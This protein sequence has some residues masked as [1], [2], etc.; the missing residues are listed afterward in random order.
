V[1]VAALAGLGGFYLSLAEGKFPC[2]LCFYQRSFALAV[3]A[4]LLTG[5]IGGLNSR[6]CLATLALPLAVAGLGVALWH[7]DLERR[8][9]LTCPP[10]LFGVATAPQ[11]S[12]I[13]F[14]LLCALLL[15]DTYQ[16][17]RMGNDFRAVAGAVVL[18]LALAAACC[19]SGSNKQPVR[20]I[21]DAEYEGSRRICLPPQKDR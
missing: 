5:Q 12:M 16:P 1:V 6:I 4:V 21:P 17:G 10:G 3:F 8:G 15:L 13:A 9:A 14:A 2:P 18:G 20:P 11:Q 7:V 19:Y